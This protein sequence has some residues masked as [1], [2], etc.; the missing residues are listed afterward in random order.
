VKLSA[1][2][3]SPAMGHLRRMKWIDALEKKFGRHAIHGLVRVIVFLNAF[4]F[5]LT[6]VNPHFLELIY[7]DPALVMQGQVWRLFSYILIP[8]LGR[9]WLMPDYLWLVFW[10][11]FIWML[12]E[13]LEHA[14]GSFK[15]NM[16]YIIG[17]LGTTVAAF[18]FGDN[19][20]NV[21]LNLSLL[22]AFATIYPDY[23]IRL[24]LIIPVKIK[25]IAWFSF[26]GLCLSFLTGSLSIRMAI[27]AGLANYI[28]FFS[29]MI[30]HD[31]KHRNA[32]TKRRQRFL[33]EAMPA[34]EALHRC[35][36]CSRT[37]ITNPDLDFRVSAD[38]NEYCVEH[39]PK[40]SAG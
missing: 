1:I 21:I 25:W 14:W 29:G 35:E 23:P 33:K 3:M 12:G 40:L 19:F 11:M 28:I 18:V 38:G 39:L 32:V 9:W 31:F 4:V 6:L 34:D 27:L 17:M 7:L 26:G 30:V 37:E 5:I 8:A 16:Y 36:V 2:A 15:L 13:G 22:F 20:N 24:F 10:L